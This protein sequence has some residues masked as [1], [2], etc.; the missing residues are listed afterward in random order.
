MC[1]CPQAKQAIAIRKRNFF[2]TFSVINNVLCQVFVV[3]PIKELECLFAK[4]A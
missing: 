3:N 2:N 4:N 1:N